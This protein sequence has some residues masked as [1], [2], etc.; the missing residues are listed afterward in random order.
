MYE[1]FRHFVCST[2]VKIRKLSPES[3]IL[4]VSQETSADVVQESRG[5]GAVRL[6]RQPTL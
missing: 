6:R 3:K 1:P 5:S 4:F 2:L